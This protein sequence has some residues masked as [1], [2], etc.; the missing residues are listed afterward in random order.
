HA[1]SASEPALPIY[2]ITK[3]FIAATALALRDAGKLD[4]DVSIARWLPELRFAADVTTRQLLQHTSG[5]PDYGAMPEYQAAVRAAPGRP[6]S[7]VEFAAHTWDRGLAFAPGQGWLYS[8]PGYVLATRVCERA[9]GTAFAELLE[10][11]VLGPLGLSATF[12]A[13]TQADVGPIHPGWVWHGVLVSSA[14]DVAVFLHRLFAGALLPAATLAEMT[15]AVRVP[16]QRAPWIDPGY[17][18]GL[19]IASHG[20]VGAVLGHN[21]SGPG[22]SASAFHAASLRGRGVTACALIAVEDERVPEGV[23]LSAL[24]LAAE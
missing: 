6:W 10:A 22:F 4:L 16:P 13:R 18:L 11:H 12:L 14:A 1:N 7:D 3:S 24:E 2:S 9:G 21:G 20:G 17:G 8:N 15:N 23:V 19:M 5:V